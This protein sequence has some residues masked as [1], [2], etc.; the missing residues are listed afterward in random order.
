MLTTAF[1]VLLVLTIS[2]FVVSPIIQS[3]MMK[4]A[5]NNKNPNLQD[6]NDLIERKETV[7]SQIK[8]IEFDY[9]M[10]KLSESDFKELR[11]QYKA[12][13][14]DLLKQIDEIQGQDVRAKEML[15]QQ[16]QKKEASEH[17][18]KYCWMCGTPVTEGDRF[19]ASC[20]K[21]L[22]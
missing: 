21:E 10:G 16:Q 17:G 15:H 6:L 12:E 20:G 8:D 11:Q 7:Y 1:F 19:C 5:S 9:Q 13:A 18:V 22:E 2:F 14:V 3:R 4:G